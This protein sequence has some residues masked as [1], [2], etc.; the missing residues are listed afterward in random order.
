M[1]ELGVFLKKLRIENGE[2]LLDMAKRLGVSAAFL[3]AVENNRRSAPLSWVDT[4][5]TEYQLSPVQRE[6][7]LEGI[8]STIKQV[9]M[10]VGKSSKQQ[11]NCALAFA[12][13]FD[14]LSDTDIQELMEILEKRG[15]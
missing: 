13:K 9:R 12:R 5:S 11:R 4:I 6:E 1:N 8:N 7:L 2:V 10:D 15:N 14:D 3:S